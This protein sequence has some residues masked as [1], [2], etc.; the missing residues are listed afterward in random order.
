[1]FELRV[2]TNSVV[3]TDGKH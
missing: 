1:L 3:K 2:E